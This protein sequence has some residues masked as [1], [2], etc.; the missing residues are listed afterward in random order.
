MASLTVLG[1]CGWLMSLSM[2]MPRISSVSSS[3]P[4]TLPSTLMRSKLTSLRSIVATLSTASTAMSA[5]RRLY[6]FTI[7]ELSVVMAV[8]V[9]TS[10]SSWPSPSPGRS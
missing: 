6:L 8:F 5:M 10:R 4:P 2:M 1:I 3:V 9:S 7:L